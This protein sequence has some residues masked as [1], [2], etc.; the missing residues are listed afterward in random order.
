MNLIGWNKVF[1]EH[2]NQLQ[3]KL[4]RNLLAAKQELKE[5]KIKENPTVALAQQYNLI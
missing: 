4:W 1:I 5:T 2:M 3:P